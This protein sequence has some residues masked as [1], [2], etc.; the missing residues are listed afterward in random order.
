MRVFQY[1]L[2]IL[3]KG[4]ADSMQSFALLGPE[5]FKV[6]STNNFSSIK[7]GVEEENCIVWYLSFNICFPV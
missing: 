5:F 7:F 1:F 6:N 4:I 2:K 3:L